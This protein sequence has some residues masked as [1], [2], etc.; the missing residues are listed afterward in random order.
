MENLYNITINFGKT[1][2][3]ADNPYI[4]G[5]LSRGYD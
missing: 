3:W 2:G 5:P 1:G 4:A